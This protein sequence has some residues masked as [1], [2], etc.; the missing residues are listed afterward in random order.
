[1][2]RDQFFKPEIVDSYHK[3]FERFPAMDHAVYSWKYVKIAL[4]AK[5]M[6]RKVTPMEIAACKIELLDYLQTYTMKTGEDFQKYQ[7]GL[8]KIWPNIEERMLRS[9]SLY[10]Y[11]LDFAVRSPT[12]LNFMSWVPC[13][14]TMENAFA[15]GYN[16]AGEYGPLSPTDVATYWSV[17][18]PV[19]FEI[20]F[21]VYYC[22]DVLADLTIPLLKNPNRPALKILFGGAGRL[23]ELR[24][25]GYPEDF[26]RRQEIVA[27]DEDEGVW[28]NLNELFYYAHQKKM[29]DFNIRYYNMGIS[30]FIREKDWRAYFDVVVLQGVMSYYSSEA[31]TMT[32]LRDMRSLLKNNGLLIMDLQLFHISLLRCKFALD[33][34][35]TPPL[36]PDMSEKVAYQRIKKACDAVGM[37]IQNCTTIRGD[38][39]PNAPKIGMAFTL[40]RPASW[41]G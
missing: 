24:R 31:Q 35:T 21:R 38:P 25:R 36:S 2:T 40:R 15:Y 33:W 39:R 5:I 12:L 23:P 32:M 11:V 20:V 29:T 17:R 14:E 41:S 19:L 28:S 26:L 4:M 30:E 27:V 22:Q 34:N 13:S 9:S 1:M 6:H 37:I 3:D 7:D 8:E 10:Q 16:I 18:E